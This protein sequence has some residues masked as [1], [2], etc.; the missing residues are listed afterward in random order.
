MY[1]I[2]QWGK[3]TQRGQMRGYLSWLVRWACCTGP[4][5]F[6]SA[7]AA[8]VDPVQYIF[9]SPYTISIPLSQSPSKLDRQPSWVACLLVCV[10][11]SIYF[12]NFTGPK[13][14]VGAQLK[15]NIPENKIEA[16]LLLK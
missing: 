12:H 3:G 10:T 8:L 2:N 14:F 7:L 4:G 1:F 15:E 9:S 13:H 16:L 11:G 6:S 5:D